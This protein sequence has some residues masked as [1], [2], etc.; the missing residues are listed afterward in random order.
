M[1]VAIA[2]ILVIADGIRRVSVIETSVAAT[3]A[4]AVIAFLMMPDSQCIV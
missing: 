3:Y 4:I 2:Y 1:F